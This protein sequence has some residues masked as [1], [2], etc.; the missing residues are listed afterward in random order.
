MKEIFS[1]ALQDM[2]V[3]L[4]AADLVKIGLFSSEKSCH[5]ARKN[6]YFLPFVKLR[7]RVFFP[8]QLVIDY[9]QINFHD[10]QEKKVTVSTA[11]K[12]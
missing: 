7:R 10:E 6:G 8:K 5:S 1:K 4:R 3:M 12:Q 2:P 9:L 11:C